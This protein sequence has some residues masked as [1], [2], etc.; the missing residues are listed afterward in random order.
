MWAEELLK[1]RPGYDF[2]FQ[3]EYEKYFVEQKEEMIENY[4]DHIL[5]VT[6]SIS[7]DR[8]LV[9]NVKGTRKK[10]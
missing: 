4:N 1:I 6:R 9:W 3:A 5:K 2:C 10:E 8:L 7:P